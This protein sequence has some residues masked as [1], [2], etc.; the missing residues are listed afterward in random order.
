[1]ST[2]KTAGFWTN[3]SAQLKPIWKQFRT[4]IADDYNT[5]KELLFFLR[6]NGF[7]LTKHVY[8]KKKG[9]RAQIAIGNQYCYFYYGKNEE[10]VKSD[11]INLISYQINKSMNNIDMTVDFKIDDLFN[12]YFSK[13][14]VWTINNSTLIIN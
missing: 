1:M 4:E 9:N 3:I 5:Y 11:Y 6:Q 8:I 7:D 12:T 13:L 10:Q 14:N 2:I